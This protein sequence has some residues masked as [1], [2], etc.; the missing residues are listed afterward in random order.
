MT[1]E[2]KQPDPLENEVLNFSF[3]VK[4]TNAILNILGQA[5]YVASAGLIALIQQQG[6]PQFSKLLETEKAKNESQTAT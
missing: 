3:T 6:E 1:D 4:Q 2:V 5:P